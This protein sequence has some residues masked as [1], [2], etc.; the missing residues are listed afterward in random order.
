MWAIFILIL[1]LL[2]GRD[3]PEISIWQIDKVIHF[4]FYFI[5]VFLLYLAGKDEKID[6][7]NL[8]R[9]WMIASLYG[10]LIEC[11]QGLFMADRFFDPF[12][13]IANSIGSLIAALI[14]FVYLRRKSKLIF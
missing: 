12:D 9:F 2:P 14:L 8:F 3:L 11:M 7:R 5:L 10:F 6:P 1:S 13:E 4:L